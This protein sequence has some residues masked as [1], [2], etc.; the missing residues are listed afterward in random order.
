MIAERGA[1]DPGS[2]HTRRCYCRARRGFDASAEVTILMWN[3]PAMT[4]L[5]VTERLES[6][7][8]T[9]RPNAYCVLCITKSLALAQVLDE[10]A[11][12]TAAA[13]VAVLPRGPFARATAECS[14]CGLRKV[15]VWAAGGVRAL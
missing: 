1:A 5:S 6:F 12:A 8:R 14:R 7:L 3:D 11:E 4:M 13:A 10:E 15:V 9:A 2:R